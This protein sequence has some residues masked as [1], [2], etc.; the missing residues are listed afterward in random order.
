MGGLI[1]TPREEDFRRLTADVVMTIYQEV[2]LIDQQMQQ[3]IDELK[4]SDYKESTVKL[5]EE[6]S[7]TVGIVSGQKI[8]FS[9]NAPYTAKGEKI[10]GDQTVEFSE[11]GILWNG[12]QYRELTFMPQQPDASF[13]LY[14]VP[15]C[16]NSLT[17][18]S[19]SM[20]SPSASISIGSARRRRCSWARLS[21]WL[22]PIRLRLSTNCLSNNILPVL[23]AA[24]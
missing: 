21:W 20:M 3:V 17:P 11:G 14:D 18:R 8:H 1:I 7:V 6:P 5:K 19:H 12:N 2:S 10:E 16:P 9:L 24:R 23:S 13:S 15:S 4:N 22:R